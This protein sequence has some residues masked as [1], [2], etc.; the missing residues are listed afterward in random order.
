MIINEIVDKRSEDIT[1][2]PDKMLWEDISSMASDAIDAFIS[3]KVMVKGMDNMSATNGLDTNSVLFTKPKLM[4]R[5]SRYTT[6]HYTKLMDTLPSWKSYPKRS[7]SIICTTSPRRAK[8]F[9]PSFYILPLN[10]AKIGVCPEYDL[11]ESFKNALGEQTIGGLQL[12]NMALTTFGIRENLSEVYEKIFDIIAWQKQHKTVNS[13]MKMPVFKS[14]A[15]NATTPADV[16]DIMNNM[17]GPKFNNFKLTTINDIPEK[18]Y[19][20]ELWTDSPA[21][22]IGLNSNINLKYLENLLTK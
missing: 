1:Q 14:I 2:M 4:K 20:H 8:E 7:Q 6:N 13:F 5:K 16:K 11:W 10:G 3:N 19:S 9:G 15:D 22:I 21:Y 12:F 17:M 18:S